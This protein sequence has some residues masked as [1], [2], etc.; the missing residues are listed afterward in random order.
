MHDV[1]VFP[2]RPFRGTVSETKP[3]LCL[4]AAQERQVG[5]GGTW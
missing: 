1:R 4:S 2:S 5:S 3:R